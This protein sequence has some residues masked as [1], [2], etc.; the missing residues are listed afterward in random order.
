MRRNAVVDYFQR[1]NDTIFE[2]KYVAADKQ[3]FAALA[4]QID[5]LQPENNYIISLLSS[6]KTELYKH[7]LSGKTQFLHTYEGL[8]VEEYFIKIVEDRNHNHQWDPA[9]YSNKQTPEYIYL[10]KAEGLRANFTIEKTIEY[11]TKNLS[12]PTLNKR[13]GIKN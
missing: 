11:S 4:L 9:K 1:M 5:S 3:E 7:E 8:K 12:E 13:Q 6:D 2:Q 10:Q